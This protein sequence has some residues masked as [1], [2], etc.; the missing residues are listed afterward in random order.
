MLNCGFKS[1]RF[2]SYY[3]PLLLILKKKKKKYFFKNYLFIIKFIFLKKIINY[4]I[5]LNLKKF[6]ILLLI[7]FKYYSNY[8]NYLK[9]IIL[10][11]N[12]N[13]GT[14]LLINF[15]TSQP[16]FSILNIKKLNTQLT[17]S[18]ITILKLL[19]ISKKG[20]KKNNKNILIILNFLKKNIF[21][22]IDLSNFTVIFKII[23]NSQKIILDFLK[24]IK[25]VNIKYVLIS[26]KTSYSFRTYK[27]IRSIKRRLRK[28][29][30]KSLNSRV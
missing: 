13:R 21:K 14:I 25:A 10:N 18:S 22:N 2:K 16:F 4:N 1:Y 19:K 17:F 8:L 28:K 11:N 27:K 5:N 23:K 26:K 24:T 7:I 6:K 30:V 15:K 3:P 9:N 20:L 12:N 29:M